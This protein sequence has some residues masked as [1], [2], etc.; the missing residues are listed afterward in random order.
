MSCMLNISGLVQDCGNSSV[1]TMELPQ[2]CVKP[3]ACIFFYF[4]S[5]KIYKWQLWFWSFTPFSPVVIFLL[6]HQT[7]PAKYRDKRL[8]C[9]LLYLNLRYWRSSYGDINLDQHWLRLWLVAWQHQAINW[10][11]DFSFVR[12]CGSNL[13]AISKWLHT[14]LFCL[15]CFKI[16]RLIS[17]RGQW[18]NFESLVIRK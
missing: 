15:M 3:V 9:W 2:S 13:K 8:S 1:L 7:F 17:S 14:L 10:P 4:M 5:L 12:F 18:V 11:N 6:Q 16:I